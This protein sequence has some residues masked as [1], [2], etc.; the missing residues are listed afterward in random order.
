MVNYPI[1]HVEIFYDFK[2]Y[3][4]LDFGKKTK[5]F[6]N[7]VHGYIEL[8]FVLIIMCLLPTLTEINLTISSNKKNG[9]FLTIT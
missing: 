4:T 6:L 7:Q 2:I 9:N 1:I 3:E 8:K 5:I